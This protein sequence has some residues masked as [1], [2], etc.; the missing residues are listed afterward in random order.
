MQQINEDIK[1]GQFKQMYLLCGEEAYLRRQYRDKLKAALNDGA[2]MS[3][4]TTG[5]VEN[6]VE[7]SM[8][9]H[10]FE[11]KEQ[12]IGEIIDLAETL[13]FFA[14]RRVMVLENTGLFKSGE[15]SWRNIWLRL[16]LRLILYS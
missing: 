3:F 6:S 11:G 8:N 14:E 2:S 9:S 7:N 13:P 15:K 1:S 5:F 16:R 12:N 4:G 10:Y